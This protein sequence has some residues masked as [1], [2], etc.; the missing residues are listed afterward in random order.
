[1]SRPS[2]GSLTQQRTRQDWTR[3]I[4]AM[5]TERYPDALKVRL[6][7]DSLNIHEVASLYET[8]QLA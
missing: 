5:L 6:V 1:M 2:I 4:H 8:R 7:V 3:F